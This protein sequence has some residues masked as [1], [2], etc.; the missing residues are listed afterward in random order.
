MQRA[1]TAC[2]LMRPLSVL[3]VNRHVY[4][5]RAKHCALHVNFHTTSLFPGNTLHACPGKPDATSSVHRSLKLL[6]RY[7]GS[8]HSSSQSLSLA[9]EA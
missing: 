2:Q 3:P 1:R 4:V 8:P 5:L 9:R 7:T 6:V